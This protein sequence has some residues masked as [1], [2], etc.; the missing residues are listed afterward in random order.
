MIKLSI[1]DELVSVDCMDDKKY[2]LLESKDRQLVFPLSSIRA[3]GKTSSGRIGI[4][5]KENESVVSVKLL[6]STDNKKIG[7]IGQRGQEKS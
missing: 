6:D 4:S 2:V 3:S 5:L 7:K 1:G